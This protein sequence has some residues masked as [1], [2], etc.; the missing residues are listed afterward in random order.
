[1]DTIPL[2]I[3]S[4]ITECQIV[5]WSVKPGD[6]VEQFDPICEVSSD[7][8]TV[9]ITSRFDGT[10]TSLLYE[11]GDV[12]VVGQPILTLDVTDDTEGETSLA[13][14]ILE[15]PPTDTRAEQGDLAKEVAAT[16]P[17]PRSSEEATSAKSNALVT[18]AIRHMLKAGNIKIDQVN[19]TG[20]DGRITKDDVQRHISASKSTS[21]SKSSGTVGSTGDRVVTFT[22]TENAMF[23]S[24]TES[25]KIP[26][27]L[28][29]H[30]ID[31]TDTNK[32]RGDLNS[33]FSTKQ[34]VKLTPLPL[35]MKAVSQALAQFPK[36]NSHL[37]TTAESKPRLTLKAEHNIGLAIDTPKGLV[38]PVV[39]GVQNH[40]IPSL[41]AE[42]KRLSEL[43]QAG[44][45]APDDFRGATFIVSN[46]GSIGGDA[47]APVILAP[48]VGIV[49][50]GRLRE[51]PVFVKDA[52]GTD[53]ILKRE[54]M[55]LSWSADHRVIDGA[56]AAR[57]AKAAETWIQD[58]EKVKEEC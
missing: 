46:V 23:G 56:T 17:K 9:E 57:A 12:A 27:F 15:Q 5:S 26:H 53:Q 10:I 25:L 41:A 20:K 37:D 33:N 1:M 42:I 36:L 52:Q 38:V 50:V 39:R 45:L 55:T 32:L 22:P 28:F 21:T 14:S 58:V 47:V 51:V 4:G 34:G 43:A 19:G 31:F 18:P 44:R 49:G 24:M 2:L 48:M 8:A 11:E 40:T 54:Q 6:K 30:S 3:N 7:K 29:T 13:Q 16:S 35:I